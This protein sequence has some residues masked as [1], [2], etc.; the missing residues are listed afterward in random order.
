MM[1]SQMM[2][3]LA[4]NLGISKKQAKQAYVQHDTDDKEPGT[5]N[6]SSSK[7]LTIP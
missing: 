4:Q 1:Q 7:G 5:F 3:H 6:L 2:E